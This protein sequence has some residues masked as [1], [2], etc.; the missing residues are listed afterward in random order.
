M[1]EDGA[2]SVV[3][4]SWGKLRGKFVIVA[5]GLKEKK[6]LPLIEESCCCS[7]MERGQGSGH[8]NWL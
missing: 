3:A 2:E 6:S 8:A 7:M 5:G 1:G 4:H